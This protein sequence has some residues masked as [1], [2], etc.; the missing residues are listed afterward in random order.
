MTVYMCEDWLEGILCG[1]YDAWADPA[2]H[3]NFR[4]GVKG[5]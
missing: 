1:G 4:R 5:E 3:E 2:G